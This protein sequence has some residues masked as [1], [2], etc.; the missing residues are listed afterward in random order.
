[1]FKIA[2]T[3]L[4][5]SAADPYVPTLVSIKAGT[6][7][8]GPVAAGPAQQFAV[9]AAELATCKTDGAWGAHTDYQGH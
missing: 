7:Q 9:G 5:A 4:L 3:P 8:A 1:M 6:A 2:L